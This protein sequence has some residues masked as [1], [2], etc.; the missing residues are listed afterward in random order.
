MKR[1]FAVS[2]A[3]AVAALGA[4]A[5]ANAHQGHR[6]CD[7]GASPFARTLQPFGQVVREF[8]VGTG[9]NEEVA[10]LHETLCQPAPR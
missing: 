2:A 10:A 5:P 9:V 3:T 7:P 4:A 6:D 8:A 1:I